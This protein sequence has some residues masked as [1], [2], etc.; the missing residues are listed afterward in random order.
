MEIP[1]KYKC[2]QNTPAGMNQ[3][4]PLSWT[5]GPAG[6]K[7]YAVTLNHEAGDQS[8]HWA[9]WDIPA[10]VTSLAEN[11]E[12]A[13]MPAVPAG[14]KQTHTNL[15]GFNGDGYLGPCPQAANARQMYTYRVFAL[16]VTT[17]AGVTT[18][19]STAAAQTAIKAAALANGTAKLTGTQIKTP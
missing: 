8:A 12:H 13:L 15:D 9:M 18:A 14:A 6:T 2:A 5:P 10:N 11:V 16:G 7:S 17:L 3:T 1:L 4:P 19:S